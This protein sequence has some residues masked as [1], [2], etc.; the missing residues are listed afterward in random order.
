[1]ATGLLCG[2]R[3]V[4]AY[5]V[6]EVD[7]VGETDEVVDESVISEEGSAFGEDDAGGASFLEFAGDVLHFGG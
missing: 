7:H 4:E 1:M 3:D 2:M 5:W 6:A